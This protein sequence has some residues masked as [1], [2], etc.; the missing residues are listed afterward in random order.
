[1][2]N[3]I[4]NTNEFN[5]KTEPKPKTKTNISFEMNN[6]TTNP[7]LTDFYLLTMLYSHW[8]N[9]RHND[10]SVFDMYFRKCP[11]GMDV[12]KLKQNKIK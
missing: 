8:E 6:K 9:K 10:H 7:L 2:E 1:M 5:E 11:F 3:L 12:N 4:I